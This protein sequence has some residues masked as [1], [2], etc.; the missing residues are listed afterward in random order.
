[1]SYYSNCS[2]ET[3]ATF[4]IYWYL[5]RLTPCKVFYKPYFSFYELKQLFL[6]IRLKECWVTQ[7]DISKATLSYV[8]LEKKDLLI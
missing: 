5:M 4:L 8:T 6:K 3:I 2:S 1:M 7:L